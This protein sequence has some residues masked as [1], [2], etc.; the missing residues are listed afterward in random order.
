MRFMHSKNFRIKKAKVSEGMKL[1][2]HYFLN[3]NFKIKC[4]VSL[5]YTKTKL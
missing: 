4:K 2:Q 1:F 3:S 5:Q